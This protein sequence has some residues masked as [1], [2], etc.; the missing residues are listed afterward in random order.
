MFQSRQIQYF[1][2]I[3][4]AYYLDTHILLATPETMSKKIGVKWKAENMPSQ[5]G[6]VAII[7]G[8]S[9]SATT[10]QDSFLTSEFPIFH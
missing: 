3:D 2:I 7:T 4:T 10:S 9:Y 8:G 6:K 1:Q 5:E